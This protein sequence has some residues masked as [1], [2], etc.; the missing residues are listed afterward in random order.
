MN[1]R[2]TDHPRDTAEY[3]KPWGPAYGFNLTARCQRA[4][5]MHYWNEFIGTARLVMT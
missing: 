1:S 5:E 3:Y 2:V 4:S